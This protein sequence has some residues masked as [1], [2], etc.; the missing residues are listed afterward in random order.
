MMRGRPAF[1]SCTPGVA[2]LQP[3][4]FALGSSAYLSDDTRLSFFTAM[5]VPLQRL[6]GLV[7]SATSSGVPGLELNCYSPS[8]SRNL[9]FLTFDLFPVCRGEENGLGS[10][11]QRTSRV[12]STIIESVVV[13]ATDRENSM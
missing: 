11:R 4:R 1:L 6:K 9:T 13:F 2:A 12:L 5:R 7:S 8:R 3:A 10:P